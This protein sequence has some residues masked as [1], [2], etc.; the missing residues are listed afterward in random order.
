MIIKEELIM[1]GNPNSKYIFGET[2][3]GKEG[4]FTLKDNEIVGKLFIEDQK[5]ISLIMEWLRK[6]ANKKIEQFDEKQKKKELIKYNEDIVNNL[7]S[8]DLKSIIE[9]FRKLK[10]NKTYEESWLRKAWDKYG[11]VIGIISIIVIILIVNEALKWINMK[12]K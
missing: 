12:K 6:K 2:E 5:D 4:I 1:K 11:T 8:N 7:N 3:D 9:E 10:E